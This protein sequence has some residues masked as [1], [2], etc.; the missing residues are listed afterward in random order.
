[1]SGPEIAHFLKEY[2]D[3]DELSGV[4]NVFLTG[5]AVGVGGTVIIGVAGYSIYRLGRWGL[6]KVGQYLAA[7][8][9]KGQPILESA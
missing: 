2:G 8:D 9:A 3:G 1:M 4:V 6:K 5:T 7:K